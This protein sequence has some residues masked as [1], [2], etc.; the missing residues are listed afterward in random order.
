MAVGDLAVDADVAG[1]P[2]HRALAVDVVRD[3]L[4]EVAAGLARDA[5]AGDEAVV[6]RDVREREVVRVGDGEAAREPV[7]VDVAALDEE[8]RVVVD[9]PVGPVD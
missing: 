5:E 3:E 2:A 9:R 1:E 6:E 7:A 4:V 8:V